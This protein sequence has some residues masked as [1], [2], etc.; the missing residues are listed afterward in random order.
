MKTLSL[1]LVSIITAPL[2]VLSDT[3][4]ADQDSMQKRKN[5]EGGGHL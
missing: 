1:L 4:V 5:V 2:P 3:I